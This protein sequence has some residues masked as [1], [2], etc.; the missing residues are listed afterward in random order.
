MDTRVWREYLQDVVKPEIDEPSV[1]LVDNLDSHVSE[2]S[3][4][5]VCGELYSQLCPLPP[6]STS[7]AQPLDVGVMGPLKSK[8]RAAW[9]AEERPK[10]PTAA[11][12]RGIMINR[13]IKMF[14]ELSV[15]SIKSSFAKALPVAN[16]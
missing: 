14:S 16:V 8:L 6:N 7:V 11:Q 13:T 12:M 2:E 15:E 5:I 9:L 1:L 3:Y 4:N 10:K